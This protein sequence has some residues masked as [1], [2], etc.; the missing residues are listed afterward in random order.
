MVDIDKKFISLCSNSKYSVKNS[1]GIY[2]APTDF[3]S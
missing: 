1:Y 3:F 2:N